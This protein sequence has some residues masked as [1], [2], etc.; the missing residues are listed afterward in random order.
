MPRNDGETSGDDMLIVRG[1]KLAAL[2][3]SCSD[4]PLL[5]RRPGVDMR[6][7]APAH[8]KGF[9]VFPKF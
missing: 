1:S 5:P 7:S 3:G 6:Q 8:L 2:R 4:P 9:T